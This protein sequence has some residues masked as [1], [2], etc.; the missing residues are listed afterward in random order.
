[1]LFPR[2]IIIIIIIIVFKGM[3][4]GRNNLLRI[5]LFRIIL[6]SLSPPYIKDINLY[7]F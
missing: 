4:E 7:F 2:G 3:F 5:I 1:M 6:K